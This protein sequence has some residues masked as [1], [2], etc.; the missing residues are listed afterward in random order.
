MERSCNAIGKDLDLA[1]LVETVFSWTLKDVLNE[2][3]CKHKVVFSPFF[4]QYSIWKTH[5]FI[6]LL[7]NVRNL[8]NGLRKMKFAFH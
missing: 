5:C 7:K 2:N 1:S 3:L 4:I 8:N 6:N